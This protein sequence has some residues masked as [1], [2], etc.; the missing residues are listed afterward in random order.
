MT[1]A[2][3]ALRVGRRTGKRCRCIC[4]RVP[5][6]VHAMACCVPFQGG[7]GADA[8]PVE[9]DAIVIRRIDKTTAELVERARNDDRYKKLTTALTI[10]GVVFA[11][12]KL[13]IVTWA[14]RTSKTVARDVSREL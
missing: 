7:L 3:E 8:A 6:I 10:A 5:G 1:P 14:W 4:H 12:F 9:T 2:G 13:G 11:A